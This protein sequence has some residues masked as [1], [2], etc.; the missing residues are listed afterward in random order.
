[1][2]NVG[3]LGLVLCRQ[4]RDRAVAVDPRRLQLGDLRV[5]L[6]EADRGRPVVHEPGEAAVVEV[7]H[8]R[9]VAVDEQVRDAQVGMGEAEAVGAPG[10]S[11]RAAGGSRRRA[12]SA[13]RARPA[14][15]RGR[16]ASDPSG[17][18][19]RAWSS[20]PTRSARTTRAASTAARAGACAPR[21]RRGA[22]RRERPRRS[23]PRPST[24]SKSTTLRGSSSSSS[25]TDSTFAPVARRQHGRRLDHGVLAQRLEPGQLGLDL[26]RVVVAGAMH[27]QRGAPAAR[28]IVDAERPVLGDVDQRRRRGSGQV[29]VRE[30]GSREP[31]ELILRRLVPCHSSPTS[32]YW[33]RPSMAPSTRSIS[34]RA[35]S[36]LA[37]GPLR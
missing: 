13:A 12:A 14:S 19:G 29:V 37:V 4:R 28:R 26:G 21:R 11:A 5:I 1:M 9:A 30:R 2:T 23:A 8:D 22:G 36:M 15:C 20:S 18:A 32:S 3:E 6:H 16:P 25:E 17:R 10:R 31:V 27:A 24:Q 34:S 33:S 35:R 7:D